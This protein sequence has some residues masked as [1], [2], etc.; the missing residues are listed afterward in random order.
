MTIAVVLTEIIMFFFNH[1]LNKLSFGPNHLPHP[2]SE[3]VK[4]SL[5][6]HQNN[7]FSILLIYKSQP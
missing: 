5:F 2:K 7:Y 6:G 3:I 4:M 1:G